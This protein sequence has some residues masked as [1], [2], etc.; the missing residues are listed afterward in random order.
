[1]RLLNVATQ[2][3]EEFF[4][5]TIP[6]FA[7]LSHTWGPEEVTLP[8][9]EIITRHR[10][11]QQKPKQ[12]SV[13]HVVPRS[14]D[15]SDTMR[16]MLL[17]TMLMAF[18]GQ[19]SRFDRSPAL[20]ALTTPGYEYESDDDD[21]SRHSMVTSISRPPSSHPLERKAGYSKITYACSQAAKDGYRYVWIDTCCIDKRSSAEVSEAI[22]S[23]WSWYQ[24]AAV[25]YAY[26]ED[27]HFDDYTQ[28]YRTWKDD[29]SNSRWFTRGW[30]LQELLAPRKVVFYAKGWRILGTKSSLVKTVEKIT[31]I[32]ELTLLEPRL[33]HGASVARRMS[34]AAKRTTTRTEDV[35]YS[36]LGIFNINMPIIY[37]ES[38]NAFLRLQEE[39]IKRSDD[40]SIFA[41][42]ALGHEDAAHQ[43]HHHIDPD[44]FDYDAITGS[45]G[46][47]AQSP[48]DFA[49]MEHVVVAAPATQD[50][51]DYT[52][53]NKGLHIKLNLVR[54]HATTTQIYY[55]GVLN[56]HTED[57]PSSR[58]G[59]LLTETATPNV[60]LRTKTRTPAVISEPELA[61]AKPKHFYIPNTPTNIPQ[62]KGI[63]EIVVVRA[64][65]LIAPGYEVIDIQAKQSQW[66]KEFSTMRLQGIE[67]KGVL[68]QLAVVTFFNKHM[69]CG[70]VVRILVDAGA[71]TCFV[72]LV[73]P[74]E[75][76]QAP[77]KD[78]AGLVAAAK[79]L[80]D[81][82]GKVDVSAPGP[83]DNPLA[84][85]VT[86]VDVVNP[87]AYEAEQQR[88]TTWRSGREDKVWAV[89]PGHEIGLSSSVTFTEK[90]EKD[91]QRTVQAKLERKKKSVIE[92]SMWSMLW[93]A[94]VAQKPEELDQPS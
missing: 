21:R 44:D 38:E 54:V 82:P 74:R 1:M 52:M 4:G 13:T 94:P 31:G 92:L 89:K 8:E 59:V 24:R 22:N 42:G 67:G 72:D 17:S 90:W 6:P 91:Y 50:A 47:L 28:G 56:C 41:W 49:G 14:I 7:I 16:L 79:R 80:W 40:Q 73:Q 62:S 70:F 5:T 85:R 3:V 12:E 29:F 87:V 46:I 71:K 9:M 69:K 76:D 23:M 27:V 60:L 88:A 53:T 37:G 2:Q 63:E 10:K 43:H 11:T 19:Q 39:I 75:G 26:L 35:A 20:P 55:L 64:P 61:T 81:N 34:W 58:L 45:T 65:D 18:R 86:Q 33:V 36:L 83:K 93:A 15:K 84:K 32:D 66:N 78:G 30:T 68:Y 51:S 25:C 48:K 57:D 77:G